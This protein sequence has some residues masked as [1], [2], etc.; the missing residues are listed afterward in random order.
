MFLCTIRKFHISKKNNNLKQST[1]KMITEFLSQLCLTTNKL[2]VNIVNDAACSEADLAA[3]EDSKLAF[4]TLF[5]PNNSSDCLKLFM[6]KMLDSGIRSESEH[7]IEL[8]NRFI[9]L[10][11]KKILPP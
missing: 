4:A 6:I 8:L 10:C 9:T 11:R 5:K 2:V 3:C 1:E 7:L